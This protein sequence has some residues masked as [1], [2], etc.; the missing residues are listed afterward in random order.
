MAYGGHDDGLFSAA[1]GESGFP[2]SN[3]FFT[4]SNFTAY[5]QG[6]Y[7]SLK[8]AVGCNATTDS[9]SLECIREAPFELLRDSI[10][11]VSSTEGYF[12]PVM[13]RDIIQDY[14]STQLAQGRFI[15]VPYLMGGNTD[16]GTAFTTTNINTDANFTDSLKAAGLDDQT[17]IMIEYPYPN[18]NQIG[19]P[20]TYSPLQSMD[21]GKVGV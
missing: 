15:K 13:D 6:L 21:P 7:D 14:Q 17:I 8:V 5:T 16:E 18:I 9:D 12:P 1:I 4:I 2:T 10:G 11:N 20:A 3:P 19:I